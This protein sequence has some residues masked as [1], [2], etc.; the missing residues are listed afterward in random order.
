MAHELVPATNWHVARRR[1]RDLNRPLNDSRP[2]LE[3]RRQHC[4]DF[5]AAHAVRTVRSVGARQPGRTRSTLGTLR[6]HR[7]SHSCWSRWPNWSC[8][9]CR[10][11]LARWTRRTHR[12]CSPRRPR[13]PHRTSRSGWTRGPN[14]SCRPS[15]PNRARQTRRTHRSCIPRRPCGPGRSSIT[16]RTSRS[17][18]SLRPLHRARARRL[19]VHVE[20]IPILLRRPAHNR[21]SIHAVGNACRELH[22]QPAV[23]RAR[24]P[25]F[26]RFA[27]DRR[28]LRAEVQAFQDQRLL[29][30]IQMGS[31]A[32]STDPSA[33]RS[34]C[35]FPGRC[36]S[37]RP[38]Q[39]CRR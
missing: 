32:P 31:S 5:V 23:G 18:R 14:W 15:R 1:T 16:L 7:T 6:P 38:E 10:P 39:P 34:S 21:E 3:L 11:N 27:I 30:A 12:S 37:C 22:D 17:R 2:C 36:H 35:R 9:P 24:H 4:P 19:R 29:R 28:R 8:R 33:R 25:Q 13:R 26:V 20:H